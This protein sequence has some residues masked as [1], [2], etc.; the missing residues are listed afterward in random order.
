MSSSSV[1][2]DEKT[3]GS[4]L[5]NPERELIAKWH[6][7]ADASIAADPNFQSLPADA[8]KMAIELARA[9]FRDVTIEF[10]PGR[11]V[12]AT[13]DGKTEEDT[14]VVKKTEGNRLTLISKGKDGKAEELTVEVTSGKLRMTLKGQTIFFK[15]N[16]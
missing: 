12:I 2:A 9:K 11:R 4:P 13:F 15:K 14:Y 7:D 1:I 5:S 10:A 3:S 8:K 16:P 6:V